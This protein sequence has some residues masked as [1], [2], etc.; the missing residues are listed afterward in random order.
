MENLRTLVN[1]S[2][3]PFSEVLLEEGLPAERG[4]DPA[5]SI[6]FTFPR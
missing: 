2:G 4:G 6:A 1:I 5:N 3:P